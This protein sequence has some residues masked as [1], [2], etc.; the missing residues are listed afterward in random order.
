MS[1][2]Y[3]RVRPAAVLRGSVVVPGD[4][5]ISHR[6]LILASQARGT[7]RI[8]G[9]SRGG[10]VKNTARALRR[11]GVALAPWDTEP[12]SVRGAGLGGWREPEGVL[13][14]GNSG[15]GCRLVMGAVAVVQLPLGFVPT[16][17]EPE[18]DI[19]APWPG[20]HPLEVLPEGVLDFGNSGTGIRL[21]AGLLA[22]HPFFSILSGDRYLRRRPMR[23]IAEPLRLMG[24]RIAGRAAGTLAPLAIE[25]AR[26]SGI[27]YRSPVSSAQVKSAILFAGLLAAGETTILEPE[28]SRD[29]SERLLRFL[30]VDVR[31]EGAAV[32]LLRVREWDARDLSVPG[33]PSSAAFLVAAAVIAKTAAVCVRNV[34]VNPTRTGFFEILRAMGAR[35]RLVR[36]RE[37]CGEPVADITAAASD[38]NGIDVP[39]ELVPR[40]ID[41]F[42]ILAATA[43]FARGTTRITGAGEL[44]V[45]ESDR[46]GAMAR[47]LA[48]LGGQVR[49]LPAGLEIEG[50]HPLRGAAC[51]S[52]GDHRV[53]MSLAI[54]G[55][56]IPG[57]TRIADTA[58][59]ATSFPEF[60]DL[61]A[62]L[63]GRVVAS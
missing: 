35:V 21:M 37:V 51:A 47:E 20:A 59:V 57:E 62:G 63:G 16:L 41:E 55:G 9:L 44:R 23:R 26:L 15:T 6:A 4:K 25:G 13:D 30:G 34:C 17:D 48:K 27:E 42:P 46:I 22:A 10:D 52:H 2:H 7:T 53:A 1:L 18:V 49:E 56:A 39:P 3:A 24:A 29:H 38:L 54:A 58:C 40:T 50:G 45:K 12:L 19:E 5:S 28:R 31:V 8:S 11:L 60:W 43:L 36:R 32:R 33:D 14:F 61:L